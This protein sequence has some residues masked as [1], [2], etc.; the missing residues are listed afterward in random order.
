MPMSPPSDMR[1]LNAW[2]RA[3]S[4][5]G[6]HY[7]EWRKEHIEPLRGSVY[8]KRRCIWNAPTQN[9][10]EWVQD[11][12]TGLEQRLQALMITEWI[13]RGGELPPERL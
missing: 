10:R 7:E 6:E 2:Y 13:K 3:V 8:L 12:V 5:G 9:Y 4:L 11:Y 1:R